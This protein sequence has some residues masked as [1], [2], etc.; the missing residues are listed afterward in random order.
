M[1]S[2]TPLRR[3]SA[4][5]CAALLAVCMGGCM[6]GPP[7]YTYDVDLRN[8]SE[9]AVRVELLYADPSSIGKVRADLAPGGAYAGQL[10]SINR[11]YL[12]VRYRA[13]G[14]SV[15]EPFFITELRGRRS[16]RDIVEKDGR[17]TLAQR[18]G[19]ADENE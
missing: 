16:T 14:S 4:V 6:F 17:L 12:E 5:A 13:M 1:R 7:E 15:E 3:T 8:T 9:R 18:P 19:Q 10:R 2:A 11:A